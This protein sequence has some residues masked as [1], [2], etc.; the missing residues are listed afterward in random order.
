MRRSLTTPTH[1]GQSPTIGSLVDA[2]ADG[3]RTSPTDAAARTMEA[4][5]TRL[6]GCWDVWDATAV[7]SEILSPPDAAAGMLRA[8]RFAVRRR[9]RPC[10]ST[11]I[12]S[13][14]ATRRWSTSSPLSVGGGA[15]SYHISRRY[16]TADKAV[17]RS[18]P[19]LN[20]AGD[21]PPPEHIASRPGR[22]GFQGCE[23]SGRAAMRDLE[24]DDVVPESPRM[25]ACRGGDLGRSEVPSTKRS[26]AGRH[27]PLR[28]VTNATHEP[29]DV[30]AESTDEDDDEDGDHRG[31]VGVVMEA[32]MDARRLARQRREGDVTV[33]DDEVVI[34]H[35]TMLADHDADATAKEDPLERFAAAPIPTEDDPGPATAAP[36]R[37]RHLRHR[38]NAKKRLDGG[39]ARRSLRVRR[40]ERRR[41]VDDDVRDRAP[42][43]VDRRPFGAGYFEGH[44]AAATMATTR[45]SRLTTRRCRSTATGARSGPRG[46]GLS[47]DRAARQVR[48][49]RIRRRRGEGGAR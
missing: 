45:G 38:P 39:A 44:A 24:S 21:S 30:V 35:E 33:V 27:R 37:R 1:S 40:F 47:D 13:A 46:Q 43:A 48:E 41:F 22:G 31:G 2:M 8:A 29:D 3:S 19:I 20:E 32:A 16:L 25:R 5:A 14:P 34:V 23:G 18:R 6:E 12:S 9:D 17:D 26:P 36:T 28:D 49:G 4:S 15:R 7:T 10:G 42:S 11:P